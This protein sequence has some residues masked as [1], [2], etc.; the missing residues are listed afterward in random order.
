VV[1]EAG[2][3]L[4]FTKNRK[5]KVLVRLRVKARNER[6]RR[7]IELT[8]SGGDDCGRLGKAQIEKNMLQKGTGNESQSKVP[9]H[10]LMVPGQGTS[11]VGKL[12]ENACL[13]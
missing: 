6:K 4:R 1:S 10:K 13:D 7:G 9:G 12:M 3:Q 5:K 8:R 11:S 2:N